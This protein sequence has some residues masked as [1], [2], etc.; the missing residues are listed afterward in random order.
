MV[1]DPILHAN[2]EAAASIENR[3]VQW[4][5]AM[6]SALWALEDMHACLKGPRRQPMSS[7]TLANW[8]QMTDRQRCW[9]RSW[10][11]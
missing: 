7:Q 2:P 11:L 4:T 6:Q 8:A 3:A 5:N 9:R 1:L 10:M